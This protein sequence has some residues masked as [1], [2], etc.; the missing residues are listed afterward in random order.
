MLAVSFAEQKVLDADVFIEIGPMQPLSDV[1]PRPPVRISLGLKSYVAHGSLAAASACVFWSHAHERTSVSQLARVLRELAQSALPWWCFQEQI[2]FRRRPLRQSAIRSIR[3]PDE[4][5]PHSIHEDIFR[6]SS[7][8]LSFA[9]D[10][11]LR[12]RTQLICDDEKN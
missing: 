12:L 11:A 4:L 10:R 8:F 5:E 1:Q 6:H 9:S 7:L 3:A 2:Q